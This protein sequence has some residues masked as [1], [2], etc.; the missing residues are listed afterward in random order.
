MTGPM[1]RLK[2][3]KK[4]KIKLGNE[5]EARELEKKK[6]RELEKKEA[7]QAKKDQLKAKRLESLKKAVALKK[8]MK[9]KKDKKKPEKV[10]GVARK[11][12]TKKT[13]PRETTAPTQ[14][15]HLYRGCNVTRN[16]EKSV[17]RFYMSTWANG[18]KVRRSWM[19]MFKEDPN[20]AYNTVKQNI[21]QKLDT[22]ST[23]WEP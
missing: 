21:D 12:V 9:L 6:A 10:K 19:I 11:R 20:G 1:K 17:W 5:K 15:Q 7:G 3:P 16:D 14:Q 22:P 18:K 13:G 4:K 8:A 2:K 23:T